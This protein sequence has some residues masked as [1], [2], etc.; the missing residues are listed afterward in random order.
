MGKLGYTVQYCRFFFLVL[1]LKSTLVEWLKRLGKGAES[2]RKD[3]SANPAWPF[4]KLSMSNQ[5]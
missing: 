4:G 5:Q 3:V 1:S 2:R